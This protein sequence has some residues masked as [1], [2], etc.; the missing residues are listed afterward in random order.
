[1]RLLLV[2]DDELASVTVLEEMWQAGYSVDWARNE[3]EFESSVQCDNYDLILLSLGTPNAQGLDLLLGYRQRGGS[4]SV[5]TLMPRTSVEDRIA[6]LDA[7][8][9]DCLVKPFHID[10]MAAR[11]RALLRRQGGKLNLVYTFEDL[12]L[13]PVRHEVTLGNEPL[14]LPPKEFRLLHT[15]IEAPGHVF[16]RLALEYKLYGARDKVGSNTIESHISNL[17]R[18]IGSERLITVRGKGYKLARRH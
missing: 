12:T 2:E 11:V 6:A 15:L 8:A 9:D 4:A 10:E 18:K 1:M 13:N 16:S 3:R 14:L 7:G 17:R 5:V